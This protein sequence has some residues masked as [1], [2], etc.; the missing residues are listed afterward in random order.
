VKLTSNSDPNGIEF[1]YDP[2]AVVED[3]LVYTKEPVSMAVTSSGETVMAVFDFGRFP[4]G[5][6]V[7]ISNIS[8]REVQ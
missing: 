5:T 3:E 6:E 7:T 1:F 4:A 8:L 2:D